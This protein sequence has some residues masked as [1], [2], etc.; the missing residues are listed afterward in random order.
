MCSLIDIVADGHGIDSDKFFDHL[1]NAS[2]VPRLLK[3]LRQCIEPNPELNTKLT[4]HLLKELHCFSCRNLDRAISDEFMAV[5]LSVLRTHCKVMDTA[6][7]EITITVLDLMRKYLSHL[8]GPH[9][10]I[11]SKT[12]SPSFNK[13]A[14]VRVLEHL[15]LGGL[16]DQLADHFQTLSEEINLQS[17]LA[18]MQSQHGVLLL[19]EALEVADAL[20]SWDQPLGDSCLHFSQRISSLTAS[21]E[22][23][24]STSSSTPAT[25]TTP[26]PSSRPKQL[27][28]VVQGLLDNE[29]NN[30]S[31]ESTERSKKLLRVFTLLW[32]LS[33]HLAI[34]KSSSLR[35]STPFSSTGAGDEL[36]QIIDFLVKLQRG[37]STSVA[38]DVQ[39][40]LDDL[41]KIFASP[42]EQEKP[43][44]LVKTNSASLLDQIPPFRSH[45]QD[46]KPGVAMWKKFFRRNKTE[47]HEAV[48][49]A[50]GCRD[51]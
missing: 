39:Q 21:Q 46:R 6:S 4:L 35:S 20:E 10:E 29:A 7:L 17:D 28:Q 31:E 34:A 41:E 44:V 1:Y 27:S 3:A 22:P 24:P 49:I 30:S 15:L 43:I 51:S 2:I 36:S 8:A 5:S 26:S 38:Q 13:N 37:S 47:A 23:S 45:S 33:S 42:R 12:T 18:L 40:I 50:P 14:V 32:P 19:L 11:R 16:G 25:P 9:S 48:R